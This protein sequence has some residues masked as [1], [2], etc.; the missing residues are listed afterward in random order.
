MVETLIAWRMCKKTS[1]ITVFSDIRCWS[2]QME[3]DVGMSIHDLYK[4]TSTMWNWRVNKS[5]SFS[6]N[7][8]KFGFGAE[9]VFSE[10]PVPLWILVFFFFNSAL[11]WVPVNRLFQK[12]GPNPTFLWCA[13]FIHAL[14]CNGKSW[15]WNPDEFLVFLPGEDPKH[16]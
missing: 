3:Y 1:N 10:V 4:W 13:L 6:D 11:L 16:T 12:K 5:I 9:Q 7:A 14:L 8:G 15:T 2:E